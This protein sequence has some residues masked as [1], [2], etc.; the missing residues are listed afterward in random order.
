MTKICRKDHS[1][2]NLR[3]TSP[4]PD[5]LAD[6]LRCPY[7]VPLVGALTVPLAM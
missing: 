2:T 4:G 3:D 6:L 5:F 1:L 7:L